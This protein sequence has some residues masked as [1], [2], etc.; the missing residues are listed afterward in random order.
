MSGIN[1][2]TEGTTAG[3]ASS[4]STITANGVPSLAQNYSLTSGID[5]IAGTAGTN[6]ISAGLTSAGGNTLNSLDEIDGGAGTDTLNA[7]IATSITPG[8]LKNV[9][10]VNLTFEAAT[11]TFNA[12]N[13]T[14]IT[15]LSDVGS[16]NAGTITNL[17][18]T[19]TNLKVSDNSV[20][21]TFT[22]KSSALTGTSDSIDLE[23]ANATGGNGIELNITG[24]VET[25]NLTSSTSANNQE[26][27]STAST[28]NISGSADLDLYVDST[29]LDVATTINAS[30]FTGDLTLASNNSAAAGAV[31]ITGGSGNDSL[32]AS[33]SNSATDTVSGGAGNDTITYTTDLADADVINGGDGTDTL[34]STSALLVALSTANNVSN[35][36]VLQASAILDTATLTVANIDSS[37][38]SVTLAAGATAGTVV[39]GAG[40][41]TLGMGTA[42]TGALVVTDTGLATTDTLTINASTVDSFNDNSVAVNG[43]ETVNFSTGT[44]STTTAQTISTINVTGDPDTAGIRT[45]AT[46]NISGKANLTTSGIITLGTDGSGTGTVNASGLTGNLVMGAATAGA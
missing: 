14:G 22:Y 45:S 11:K 36:E 13:A 33:G 4:V 15:T 28:L 19:S 25:I 37:I 1:K 44:G 17:S 10:N 39:F 41:N 26:L 34:V 30:S 21:T 2:D 7:S 5:D 3:I 40:S 31:T 43:F 35:I 29:I 42:S 6:K 20:G 32:T 38:K 18:D 16:T 12:T 8:E 23:M 27:N 24:A 9:E 46:L